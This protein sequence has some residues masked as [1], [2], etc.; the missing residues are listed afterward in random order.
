METNA[1]FVVDDKTAEVP[2]HRPV[3][4]RVTI[5]HSSVRAMKDGHSCRVVFEYDSHDG[6]RTLEH[7]SSHDSTIITIV[8]T[9]FS[10]R[11]STLTRFTPGLLCK[12]QTGVVNVGIRVLRLL[13][14][15]T[16]APYE[17]VVTQ[18]L[19]IRIINIAPPGT[20]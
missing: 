1:G 11:D 19:L 16:I 2:Q 14:D 4:S 18:P 15:T 6:E 12:R 3:I 9:K 5:V 20:S 8:N 17:T 7:A 10:R 13:T